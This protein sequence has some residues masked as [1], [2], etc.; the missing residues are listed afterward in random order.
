MSAWV[1]CHYCCARGH[2]Q[3]SHLRIDAERWTCYHHARVNSIELTAHDWVRITDTEWYT[4]ADEAKR[5][6]HRLEGAL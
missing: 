1:G 3:W 5:D 2:V 6:E 4:E